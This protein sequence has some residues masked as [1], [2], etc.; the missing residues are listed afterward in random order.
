M[1]KTIFRKY[2][3]GEIIALFPQISANI[4]GWH[5]ASYMHVG[6]YGGATPFFVVSQ[7]RLAT[8]EE[9]RELYLE[10]ERIGYNPSPA[11]RF[12]PKDFKMGLNKNVNLN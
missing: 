2:P 1:D 11:T 3:D 10:L 7:T 8:P 6:Q 12:G 5:C 4:S 9:Y